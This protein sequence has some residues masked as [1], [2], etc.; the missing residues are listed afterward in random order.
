MISTAG[1]LLAALEPLPHAARLRY[2]AVAAHRLSARGWL[3]PLLTELD[4]LGPYERRLAAL[5]ALTAGEPGY[6]AAR[7]A[8]PDP[9]VR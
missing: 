9:V 2:T 5:A 1:E 6:L 7:L 3:G 8:D 4:D